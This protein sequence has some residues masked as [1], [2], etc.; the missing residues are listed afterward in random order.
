MGDDALLG[1][2]L[3]RDFIAGRGRRIQPRDDDGTSFRIDAGQKH[4]TLR[5]GSSGDR[6]PVAYHGRLG[7]DASA[8]RDVPPFRCPA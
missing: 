4:F 1:V 2:T 8:N 5:A 3:E 6:N 7:D